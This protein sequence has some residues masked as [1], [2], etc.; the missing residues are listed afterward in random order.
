MMNKENNTPS[1]DKELDVKL[2][3]FSKLLIVIGFLAIVLSFFA[4]YLF[5]LPNFKG[6]DFTETGQIGDTIGGIM[7]PFIA[8]AG[9]I[10]SGLAFYLQYRANILQRNMFYKQFQENKAQFET[11]LA[12]QKKQSKLDKFE[13]QLYEMLRL[14]KENVN[15]LELKA[16]RRT[17][18]KPY[19]E[20]GD[21]RYKYNYYTVSKRNAFVELKNEFEYILLIYKRHYPNISELSSKAFYDCYKTFFWGISIPV[22]ATLIERMEPFGSEDYRNSLLEIQNKQ[23]SEDIFDVPD[24]INFDIEAFRGHSEFLGHYFRHI[25]HTVKFVVNQPDSFLSYNEKRQYL[26]VLRAQL[27]NH[28]QIMLFYN[29]LSGYGKPWEDDKNKF[30][31]EFVM[32]HNLWYQLLIDDKFIQDKIQELR[33]KPVVLRKDKLFEID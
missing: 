10:A 33:D 3:R 21:V 7:N 22:N 17:T 11:E 24:N 25:F 19:G 30:F 29:W 6:L 8:I 23:F 15:E 20:D 14:H 1:S 4:P 32:I 16:A 18:W 5:T 12:E 2:D 13:A 28:E 31:T 9:V 26:R 27:S